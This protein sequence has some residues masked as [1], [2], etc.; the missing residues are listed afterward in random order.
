MAEKQQEVG[1]RR[2][3][4]MKRVTAHAADLLEERAKSLMECSTVDGDWGDALDAK[5]EYEDLTN[6]AKQLR[7][8]A[9]V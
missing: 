2:L 4:R 1:F 3:I 5:A 6:T 8:L 9:G 7:V